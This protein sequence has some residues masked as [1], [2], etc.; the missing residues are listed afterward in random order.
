VPAGRDALNERVL[1]LSAVAARD[2]RVAVGTSLLEV[3]AEGADERRL[4]QVNVAVNFGRLSVRDDLSDAGRHLTNNAKPQAA[5]FFGGKA[6]R[7]RDQK[8]Q[9]QVNAARLALLPKG[10]SG[11]FQCKSEPRGVHEATANPRL[12]RD[13]IPCRDRR[14]R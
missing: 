10:E 4:R 6:Q 13:E 14:L 9:G 1:P 8:A 2:K 5:F 12:K 7:H 3:A 11:L